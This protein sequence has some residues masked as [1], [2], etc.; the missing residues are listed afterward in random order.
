M[1]SR[2]RR[3]SGS[4]QPAAEASP[5]ADRAAKRLRWT[6]EL[7]DQFV[8]AVKRLGERAGI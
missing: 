5:E 8:A 3:G 7:H 2:Q 6:P 4:P 1:T